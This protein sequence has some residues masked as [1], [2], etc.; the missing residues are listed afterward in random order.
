ML[1]VIAVRHCYFDEIRLRG[2]FRDHRSY[3]ITY[4]R[5][6]ARTGAT[7]SHEVGLEAKDE[8]KQYPK[9]LESNARRLV[10]FTENKP[11]LYIHVGLAVREGGRPRASNSLYENDGIQE[12]GA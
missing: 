12:R 8:E 9:G 5:S 7:R 1:P 10:T 2:W 6:A 3:L 4:G 11:N